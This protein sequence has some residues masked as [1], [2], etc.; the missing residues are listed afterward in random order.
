[1]LSQSSQSLEG[2]HESYVRAILAPACTPVQQGGL[3][4]RAVVVNFRGCKSSLMLRMCSSGKAISRVLGMGRC[5]SVDGKDVPRLM[6]A[7]YLIS[8]VIGE[9]LPL[10][11]VFWLGIRGADSDDRVSM[12]RKVF[13]A[14][15]FHASRPRIPIS[16]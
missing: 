1:M 11:T 16:Q 5:R 9:I 14:C 4:Y 6:H 3:G 15:P 2:S 12:G 8:E 13:A 10:P 7:H